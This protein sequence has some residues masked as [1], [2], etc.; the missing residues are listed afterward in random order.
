MPLQSDPWQ[1]ARQRRRRRHALL[2]AL[3]M[4]LAFSLLVGLA[5]YSDASLLASANGHQKAAQR[6]N[7]RARP[8]AVAVDFGARAG[9]S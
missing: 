8:D 2:A 3:I 4:A 5:F 9:A 7:H 1:S 6:T